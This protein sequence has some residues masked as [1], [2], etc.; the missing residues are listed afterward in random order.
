MRTLRQLVA[1]TKLGASAHGTHWP[2]RVSLLRDFF[3][4]RKVPRRIDLRL[5]VLEQARRLA[6][7]RIHINLIFVG[8]DA[9][10]DTDYDRMEEAVY[11]LRER[12]ATGSIGVGRVERYAI[13]VAD[14]GG[15]DL[16]DE[17]CEASDLTDAWT[18]HND[19]IDVFIVRSSSWSYDEGIAAGQSPRDGPCDKDS[20]STSGVVVGRGS[21][22]PMVGHVIAHEI[23]HYL[24][25]RHIVD[26]EHEADATQD[27]LRNV[28][29]P[30]AITPYSTFIAPQATIMYQHCFISGGC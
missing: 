9:F 4:H 13:Q 6:L 7:P 21:S 25:L 22:G 2:G 30:D 14:A 18:V 5:S 16:I 10:T 28:M 19:G 1:C 20:A 12:F 27:Q 8:A 26:E 29:Y 11:F 24:G 3:G 15:H 23:G 17:D